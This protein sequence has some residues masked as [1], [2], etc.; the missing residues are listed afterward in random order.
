MAKYSLIKNSDDSI[1]EEGVEFS[2]KNPSDPR[3]LTQ[4]FGTDK[5][6]R[7]VTY[8]E[9]PEPA[10]DPNT[11]KVVKSNSISVNE[12][13]KT[14]TVV[15]LSS[16]ELQVISRR[17]QQQTDIEAIKNAMTALKNGEGTAVERL[18]RVER[19]CVWLLKEARNDI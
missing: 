8:T 17:N 7:W 11:S 15:P 14:K 13:I 12:H 19:A 2:N 5:E 3:V 16:E 18:A 4:K 10:Y 6:S 9:E 1:I